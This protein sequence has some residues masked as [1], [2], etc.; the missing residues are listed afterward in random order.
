MEDL[1]FPIGKFEKKAH[2]TA[3]DRRAWIAAL[4]EAP[5]KLRAVVAGLTPEQLRTP[6]RPGGWTVLQ[7]THHLPDS[8]LNAYV[9][10]KL[11]LTENE[12]TIKPYNEKLWAELPDSATTPVE[13]S[14][15]M[16]EAL[17]QRWVT[18]LG[19]LADSDWQKKFRHPEH[20]LMSLEDTLGIYA[21]HGRHH[22]AHIA[23]LRE[24]MA[25][26]AS[27]SARA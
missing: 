6:Y 26:P 23:A 5:A 18:L 17:H 10:F 12:P 22:V 20:G 8:H 2:V 16:L 7:V 21:W 4:A 13:T 1:R 11:A 3:E 19:S 27:S 14:L 15:V 24:R 25:W 9:R